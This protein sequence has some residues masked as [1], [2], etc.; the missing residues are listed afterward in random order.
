LPQ[1]A[2]SS[3]SPRGS[4][5]PRRA[6]G[7]CLA[8]LVAGFGFMTPALES[9]AAGTWTALTNLAP[10]RIGTML[11]LT[12]GSVLAFDSGTNGKCYKLAPNSSG[13]YVNGT[14]NSRR[15]HD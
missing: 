4:S 13:S 14:W 12:R 8:S 6:A 15:T 7:I 2:F 3:T 11:L 9:S 1:K 5:R 10:S